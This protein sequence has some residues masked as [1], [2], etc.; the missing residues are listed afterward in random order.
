VVTT[1]DWE[2]LDYS[3]GD[4]LGVRILG[5]LVRQVVPAVTPKE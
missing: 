2:G 5:L 4:A 3:A 1:T